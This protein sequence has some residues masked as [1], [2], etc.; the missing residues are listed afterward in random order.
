M[1][2]AILGFVAYIAADLG[3]SWFTRTEATNVI[4][5][6]DFLT[7]IQGYWFSM[8]LFCI[9]IVVGVWIAIPKH[10][11]SNNGGVRR[12]TERKFRS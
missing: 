4:G 7:F 12:L 2:P 1:W 3:I 8:L 10:V 9:L 5:G 6:M 11:R